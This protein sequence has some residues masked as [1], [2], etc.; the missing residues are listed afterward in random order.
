MY[1]SHSNPTCDMKLEFGPVIALDKRRRYMWTIHDIITLF[2]C[3]VL[4]LPIRNRFKAKSRDQV[5]EVTNQSHLSRGIPSILRKLKKWKV[6]F[7]PCE[8]WSVNCEWY[9]E[10]SLCTCAYT[11]H[12]WG[13]TMK[14]K[15]FVCFVCVII[16]IYIYIYIYIYIFYL[17]LVIVF[18]LRL[19][20]VIIVLNIPCLLVFI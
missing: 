18:S 7:F 8:T 1:P 2:S 20:F 11:S 19:K 9:W 10:I 5:N 17:L 14:I 4:N 12:F 3:L 6:Q 16:A 15:L 13:T